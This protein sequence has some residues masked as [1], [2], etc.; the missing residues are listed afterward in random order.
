M[1]KICTPHESLYRFNLEY[2]AKEYAD[3]LEGIGLYDVSVDYHN[4]M[5]EVTA[6]HRIKKQRMAYA[7]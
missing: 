2:Q 5:W 3:E 1:I 4:K 6:K 7:G